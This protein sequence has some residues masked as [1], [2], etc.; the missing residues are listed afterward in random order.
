M[1][2]Y[3]RQKKIAANAKTGLQDMEIEI[4]DNDAK[5]IV[6]LERLL[7]PSPKRGTRDPF[8]SFPIKMRPQMHGLVYLCK[9]TRPH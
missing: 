2:D 3:R 4:R 7:I 1:H 8:D 9:L 6:D 5:S